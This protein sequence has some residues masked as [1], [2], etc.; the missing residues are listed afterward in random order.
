VHSSLNCH[1]KYIHLGIPIDTVF[2]ACRMHPVSVTFGITM[3]MKS[4]LFP[5][6]A[7]QKRTHFVPLLRYN[8]VLVYLRHHRVAAVSSG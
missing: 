3:M 2:T 6:T 8:G 5:Y 4:G 1:H 7:N